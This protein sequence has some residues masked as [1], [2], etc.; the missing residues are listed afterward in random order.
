MLLKK[1]TDGKRCQNAFTRLYKSSRRVV[2]RMKDDD[3]WSDEQEAEYQEKTLDRIEDL[4]ESLM[5]FAR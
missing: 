2:K 5:R 3:D 4:S 1:W